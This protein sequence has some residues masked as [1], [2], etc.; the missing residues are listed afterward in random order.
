MIELTA[1][2]LANKNGKAKRVYL[3][4][5]EGTIK[6]GVYKKYFEARNIEIIKSSDEEIAEM[7]RVIYDIKAG[8]TPSLDELEE[9]ARKYEAP[10]ILGCT[11]FSTVKFKNMRDIEYIDAM[12]VLQDKILEL[13]GVNKK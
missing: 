12:Q 9:I 6:T 11:E 2:S 10:V 4:A 13:F 7:M 5:T 8:G 1:E 3:M